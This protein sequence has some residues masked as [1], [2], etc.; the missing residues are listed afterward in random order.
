MMNRLRALRVPAAGPAKRKFSNWFQK[1]IFI[2]VNPIVFLRCTFS[3][4]CCHTFFVLLS[5]YFTRAGKR[6][7]AREERGDIPAHYR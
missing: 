1:N 3:C 5:L 2:E 7:H 4:C 6:R